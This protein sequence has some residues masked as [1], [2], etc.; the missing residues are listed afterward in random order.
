MSEEKT[1]VLGRKAAA[2]TAPE[3]RIIDGQIVF[4]CP[5]GHRLVVPLELSGKRGKC[6]KCSLPIQIPE[7]RGEEAAVASP[8][9]AA[10]PITAPAPAV[11]PPP[12]PPA[13]PVVAEPTAGREGTAEGDWNFISGITGTSSTPAP[14][15][16]SASWQQSM[17]PDASPMARLLAR[18]WEEREHGGIVELH[19]AGGAVILPEEFSPR[20]SSSSHGVFASQA[21]DG[22]VTLTAVAWD[23][24]QRIVVRQLA[25]VPGDMFE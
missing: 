19:L 11:T 18:L 22:S 16:G 5:A 15:S 8:E 17:P 3:P 13:A 20:W 21:A 24:V 14:Q 2:G 6:S 10:A 25:A 1:R 23:T 4:F 9:P 7:L 12:P